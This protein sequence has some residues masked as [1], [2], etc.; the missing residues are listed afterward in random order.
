MGPGRVVWHRASGR[1]EILP[2]YP[3]QSSAMTDMRGLTNNARE[4]DLL[5]VR[6]LGIM[7]LNDSLLR[8]SVQ[9]GAP[10]VRA[11]DLPRS[12]AGQG[13]K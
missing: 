1:A 4:I 6:A 11:L 13:D 10:T 5:A 9:R 7:A 2:V 12:Y 8:A 3:S